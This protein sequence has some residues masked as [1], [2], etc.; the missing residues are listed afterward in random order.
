MAR[1]ILRLANAASQEVMAKEPVQLEAF[2]TTA[3]AALAFA[4][5]GG[6]RKHA[7]TESVTTG[8]GVYRG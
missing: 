4:I 8:D 1:H 6:L 7:G 3:L 5:A 2:F